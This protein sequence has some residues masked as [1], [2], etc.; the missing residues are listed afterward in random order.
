MWVW[1]WGSSTAL[2][3]EGNEAAVVAA[4]NFRGG[5]GENCQAGDRFADGLELDLAVAGLQHGQRVTDG[6]NESEGRIGRILRGC[7][8]GV[9][10]GAGEIVAEGFVEEGLDVGERGKVYHGGGVGGRKGVGGLSEGFR[11]DGV[12]NSPRNGPESE[13]AEDGRPGPEKQIDS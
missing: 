4:F 2:F 1:P 3:V 9:W 7:C 6:A 8:R 11:V 10:S 5:D 13:R 12:Q